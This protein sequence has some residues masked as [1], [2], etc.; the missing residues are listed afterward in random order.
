MAL[1]GVVV[2]VR[3]EYK[4]IQLTNGGECLVDIDDYKYISQFN[5]HRKKDGYAARTVFSNGKFKT[6]R[7]HREI[8]GLSNS[9][10]NIFVDHVNHNRLDNQKINI[11]IVTPSQNAAN[12]RKKSTNK[13]GYKGVHWCKEQEKWRVSI[14]VDGKLINI[15]RFKN[16]DDA[17]LMY[18]KKAQELFGEFAYLNEVGV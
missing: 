13:S 9:S 1:E 3:Q 8:L 17:A 14:R 15:G 2:L 18:N 6:I 10:R 12:A 5:W 4:I 11:R 7:M 16:L